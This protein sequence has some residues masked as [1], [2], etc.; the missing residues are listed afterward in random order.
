M[1]WKLGDR[2]GLNGSEGF[3]IYADPHKCTVRLLSGIDADA[4]PSELVEWDDP[5][6]FHIPRYVGYCDICHPK[7]CKQCVLLNDNRAQ[8]EGIEV[9][10]CT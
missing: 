4:K 8:L 3:V 7:H 5:K 6:T 9:K 10:P 1:S 2:V